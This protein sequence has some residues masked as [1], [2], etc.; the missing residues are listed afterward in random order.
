MR[1]LIGSK[2]QDLFTATT[3]FGLTFVHRAFSQC[4]CMLHGR[5]RE[6]DDC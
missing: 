1:F 2:A 4:A 3:V 6:A 5:S